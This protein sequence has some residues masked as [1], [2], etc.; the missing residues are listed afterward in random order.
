MCQWI[1][2]GKSR[3]E[4]VELC[5]PGVLKRPEEAEQGGLPGCY[6]R[7]LRQEQDPVSNKCQKSEILAKYCR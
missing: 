1:I 3:M 2:W 7:N 4:D 6:I 5:S